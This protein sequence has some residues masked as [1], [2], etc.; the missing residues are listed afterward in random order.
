M[1]EARKKADCLEKGAR[2]SNMKTAVDM[3]SF[4]ALIHVADLLYGNPK[5]LS[6]FSYEQVLRRFNL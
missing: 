3:V 5:I 2:S 4:L 6:L 1:Y